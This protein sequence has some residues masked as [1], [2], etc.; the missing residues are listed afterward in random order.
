MK[1]ILSILFFLLLVSCGKT[2]LENKL[3][4][5]DKVLEERTEYDILYESKINRLKESLYHQ[6]NPDSLWNLTSQIIK[7]YNNCKVDSAKVFM[8]HLEKLASND[9]SHRVNC[10]IT[11]ANVLINAG[12]Y[13]DAEIVLSQLDSTSMSEKQQA[14][15]YNTL[16]LLYAVRMN[17]NE[18]LTEEQLAYYIKQRY[19]TR[20]KYLACPGIDD[21]E[22]VRRSAIRMYEDGNSSE[23]ILVLKNLV[24]SAADEF[25]AHVAYS[26][27]KAYQADGDIDMTKFWFAQGAIYNVLNRS[28][29]DM[30]LYELSLILFDEQNF[31][32]A[33]SYNRAALEESLNSKNTVLIQN[34][35]SSQLSIVRAAESQQSRNKAFM[36][37]TIILLTVF[38][39]VILALWIKTEKQSNK[40]E[41]KA[42]QINIMNAELREA[43]KIKEGY[44]IGYI[45]LAA[46]YLGAIEDYRH[47]LRVT[48]KEEGV[49]AL[50]SKIR[51]T[52][53]NN[54]TTNTKQF[55]SI[56]D[57]TFLGIY[58]D[59]LEKVNQLLKPEA[60][61]SVN[62]DGEM[63]TGLRI[64]ALI[65]L[66]VSDSGKIAQF[67]NCA[68]TS[69]Y[70]HRCKIK[71]CALCPIEEFENRIL[72]IPA[73]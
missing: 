23:A 24:N 26:L 20:L 68:P 32:R 37:A 1:L 50:K 36:I 45:L 12:E 49:D 29:E 54:E 57:N 34:S 18:S 4:E 10:N 14:E 69:V 5:L 64:L 71:K 53:A 21:F 11:K 67:L 33:V 72:E 40:I 6:Q 58:P 28:G 55:Y 15:Y 52:G 65:R 62:K 48:L 66:G 70:T 38:S 47:D 16:L 30:S 22:K 7:M 43:G 2:Q 56:F 41:E 51:Q 35:A 39:L 59:F 61:F 8:Q 31:T 3:E 19:V 17:A 25:K 44:V 63:P 27:A 42:K 9:T 13:D 60:R 73:I 46:R